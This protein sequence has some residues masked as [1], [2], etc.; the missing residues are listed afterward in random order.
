MALTLKE[1]RELQQMILI[2]SG[3]DTAALGADDELAR[4][5][6]AAFKEAYTAQLQH[7]IKQNKF[8]SD[9]I[10]S[11]AAKVNEEATALGLVIPE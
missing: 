3:V 5:T 4:S 2:K 6:V 7:R 10:N 9:K 11:D 1:K 8:L